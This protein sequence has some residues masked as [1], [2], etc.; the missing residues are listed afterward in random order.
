[1]Y[2][3][4]MV[5]GLQSAQN[6]HKHVTHTPLLTNKAFTTEVSY[7]KES[8][9]LCTVGA[10]AGDGGGGGGGGGSE[11]GERRDTADEW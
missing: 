11:D 4:L 5:I 1:M 2:Q 7:S 8:R 10:G 6:W 9:Q 3:S